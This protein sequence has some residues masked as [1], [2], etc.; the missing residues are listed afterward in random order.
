MQYSGCQMET[1]FQQDNATS[2]RK[3]CRLW[4][5]RATPQPLSRECFHLPETRVEEWQAGFEA[6]PGNFVTDQ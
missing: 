2:P 6:G 4:G 3:G 5:L 1:G